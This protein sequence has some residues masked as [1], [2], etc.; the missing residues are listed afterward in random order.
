MCKELNKDKVIYH[1]GHREHR[2]EMKGIQKIKLNAESAEE[3]GVNL[4]L[5]SL[6][7]PPRRLRSKLRFQTSK[8]LCDSSVLS[9]TSVVKQCDS[10]T[11]RRAD[12][13]PLAFAEN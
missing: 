10:K 5:F 6:C 3:R 4:K 8:T 9:V 7:V 2:G 12:A 13:L 1:R 11:T